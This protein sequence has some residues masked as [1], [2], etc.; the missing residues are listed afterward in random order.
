MF[1]FYF[2]LECSWLIMF[3][4]FSGTIMHTYIYPF[5][6]SL[7]WGV[8]FKMQI[9][10]TFCKSWFIRVSWISWFFIQS[11]PVP[12]RGSPSRDGADCG[13]PQWERSLWPRSV[14]SSGGCYSSGRHPG[15]DDHRS[16]PTCLAHLGSYSFPEPG[17]SDLL[18]ISAYST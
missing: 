8:Y 18:I 6:K 5:S 2:I 9:Y 7:S 15:R 13:V 3:C 11:F 10:K 14:C 4:Y 16:E 17:S 1:N 12:K